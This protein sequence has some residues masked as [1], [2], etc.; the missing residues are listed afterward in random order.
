MQGSNGK[1][2]SDEQWFAEH[3]EA[4]GR[5]TGL[6]VLLSETASGEFAALVA[7]LEQATGKPLNGPGRTKCVHAFRESPEGFAR[8]AEDALERASYN[9]LGLLIRMVEAGEHGFWHTEAEPH[10]G[11]PRFPRARDLPAAEP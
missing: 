1:R 10:G 4:L 2:V 7:P 8:L 6:P 3:G 5:W 11:E 9:P